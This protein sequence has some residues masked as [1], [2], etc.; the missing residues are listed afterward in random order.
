MIDTFNN[1]IALFNNPNTQILFLLLTSWS[2]AW[3]GV[4][5][6]KSS[7]NSRRNWF[8]ALLLINTFGIL[9]IIY[10]FYF[11]KPKTDT[12]NTKV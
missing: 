5:L 3:K 10:I 7:R 6:W 12:Q 4:A 1:Y 11:D 9:E 2:L 8:I